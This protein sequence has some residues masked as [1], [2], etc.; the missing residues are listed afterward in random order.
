M[1]RTWKHLLIAF[2]LALGSTSATAQLVSGG[3]CG[4]LKNAY[5]PFDFRNQKAKL[6]VVEAFHFTPSVETLK[7]GKSGRLGSDIDYTLRASPNHHRA[8]MAMMKL[9]ERDKT[10]RPVG[11]NFT[12]ECYMMRAEAF[13]PDDSMVKTI[14]GLY[15]MSTNRREDALGKLDA[16]RKLE[17]ADA[18]VHYNLGLAYFDLGEHDKA[19]ESARRAYAAGFPMPGLRDKLKRAGKWL[20]TGRTAKADGVVPTSL[21]RDGEPADVKDDAAN[22]E[23]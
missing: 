10:H 19:M 18:N 15:L 5:G 4:N 7:K 21:S 23:Q 12:V 2:G 8:L 16:A 1:P 6:D 14:Y 20:E 3:A 11:A 17:D 22:A 13:R 9:A